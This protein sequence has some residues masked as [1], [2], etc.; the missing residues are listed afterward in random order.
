MFL[1]AAERSKD[2]TLGNR[3]ALLHLLSLCLTVSSI[4]RKVPINKSGRCLVGISICVN[5]TDYHISLCQ[6]ELEC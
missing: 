3:Y 5:Y 4:I 2:L 1:S 6:V